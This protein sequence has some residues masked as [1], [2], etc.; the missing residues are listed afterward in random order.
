M[1]IILRKEQQCFLF[2]KIFSFI[3]N[4]QR[5]AEFNSQFAHLHAHQRFICDAR[6]LQFK[7]KAYN[8]FAVV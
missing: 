2:K 4:Q 7:P 1:H 3:P 8:L 5:S 6:L